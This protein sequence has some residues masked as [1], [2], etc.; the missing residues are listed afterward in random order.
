MSRRDRSRRTL[1]HR[2]TASAVRDAGETL[3]EI[4][5]TVVIIGIAVTALV[6]GLAT[7]ASAGNANRNLQVA[8]SAM[9]NLAEAIKQGTDDCTVGA[10]IAFSTTPP[11][12]FTTSVDPPSPTCPAPTS[13]ATL[14]LRVDGPDGLHQTMQLVVRT[15]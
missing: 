9:R 8:D 1:R 5:M 14:T 11:S 13:T 7:T 10:P 3:V 15:P 12:G 4:V 6:S 2:A